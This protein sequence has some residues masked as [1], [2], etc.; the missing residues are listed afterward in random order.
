MAFKADVINLQNKYTEI[1]GDTVTL[2]TKVTNLETD[3][4]NIDAKVVDIVSKKLKITAKEGYIE[5]P[6]LYTN[7]LFINNNSISFHTHSLN[8]DSTG[9][10]TI[11]TVNKWGEGVKNSFNIADTK[12]YK[13]KVEA[14][15]VTSLSTLF[16]LQDYN[17]KKRYVVTVTAKNKNGDTLKESVRYSSVKA[18]DEGYDDGFDKVR[19]DTV[20]INSH[21]DNSVRITIN[22]TNGHGRTTT[23]RW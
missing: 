8:C 10:V 12:F 14:L 15:T 6:G 21:S 20:N 18:Y 2:N 3:M 4:L 11:G 23:L 22:L 16:E 13:D 9:T 1:K 5:V 17:N 7:F 19:V